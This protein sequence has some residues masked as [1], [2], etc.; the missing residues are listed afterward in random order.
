MGPN[1]LAVPSKSTMKILSSKFDTPL[2]LMQKSN[3]QVARVNA[4]IFKGLKTRTYDGL[5]KHGKKWIDKLT[6]AL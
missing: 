6:C 3:G 5:K 2:L 1:L 4:E